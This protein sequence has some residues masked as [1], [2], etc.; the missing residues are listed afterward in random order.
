MGAVQGTLFAI[1][2]IAAKGKIEEPPAVTEQRNALQ[3]AIEEATGEEKEAL[4]RELELDP[5]GLPPEEAEGGPRVA[6]GP[7]LALS[8]VELLLLH[9]PIMIWLETYLLM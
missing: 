5:L 3:Q 1:A 8:L 6:F 4:Q 7:F 2:A 9:E